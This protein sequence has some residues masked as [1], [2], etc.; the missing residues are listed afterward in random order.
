MTALFW[1]SVAWAVCFT[2]WHKN[3][4]VP[5]PLGED[6]VHALIVTAYFVLPTLAGIAYVLATQD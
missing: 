3:R 1:L 2:V 4:T 6:F 5:H